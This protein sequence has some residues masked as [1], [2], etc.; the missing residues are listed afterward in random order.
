MSYE[1]RNE[2]RV[3]ESIAKDLAQHVITARHVHGLYRHY[4]CQKPGSWNMAFD[5]VTWPG[6][7]CYTGDMGDYLFQR[8]DDMIAFMRGSCM[9]Y[10][11]AAEKCVAHD[12]R[13]ME[14]SEEAFKQTLADRLKE[15]EEGD[16]NFTVVRNGERVMESIANAIEEIKDAYSNYGSPHDAEKAMYES[17]LWDDMPRCKEYTVHFLWCLHALQWFCANVEKAETA[18]AG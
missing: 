13:L 9:S 7:L 5:V 4:R 3:K 14:W 11:Y 2:K 17:G 15:G 18:K 16:G 8:T 6:S 12:G 10:S 1:T